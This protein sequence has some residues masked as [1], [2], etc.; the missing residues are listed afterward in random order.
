MDYY[1]KEFN[2]L[3][4]EFEKVLKDY[5]L[6]QEQIEDVYDNDIEEIH[7][8]IDK[9]DEFY[10][11]KAIVKL[12]DVI[13]NIKDKSQN[14]QKQYNLFDKQAKIWD[15]LTISNISDKEL[16]NIN[17]KIKKAN[18]LIKSHNLDELI[19]ANNIM[20]DIIKTLK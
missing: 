20:E 9:N 13:E 7:E 1:I 2:D 12:K 10:L 3:Q 6:F 18:S 8:L 4:E 16:N 14:I 5:P 17:N 11:K 15:K 19:E